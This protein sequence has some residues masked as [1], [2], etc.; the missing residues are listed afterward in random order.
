MKWII[1]RN[2]IYNTLAIGIVCF[3][4]IGFG[5]IMAVGV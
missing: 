3:Y 2:A 4:A 1:E 5:V